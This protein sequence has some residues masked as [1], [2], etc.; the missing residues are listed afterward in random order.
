MGAAANCRA[1]LIG[2]AA[3]LA[4]GVGEARPGDPCEFRQRPQQ[5]CEV[6]AGE[7]RTWEGWSPNVRVTA[8]ERVYG[9]GPPDDE[10]Y[11]EWLAQRFPM[12]RYGVRGVFRICP[13][14]H[15]LATPYL[16]VSE[17][18]MYCIESAEVTEFIHYGRQS[19]DSKWQPYRAVP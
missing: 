10:I 18:E 5:A 3:F 11:P 7:M 16:G 4:I 1:A 2:A 15:S 19:N 17:I 14:G 13:L 12:P 6:V 8:S 9:I